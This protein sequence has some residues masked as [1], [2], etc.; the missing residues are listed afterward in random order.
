MANLLLEL[1]HL[2]LMPMLLIWN[3][4]KQRVLQIEIVINKI[5]CCIIICT[6]FYLF[7]Y[8]SIIH[9]ARSLNKITTNTL[10]FV[11]ANVGTQTH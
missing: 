3:A 5:N 10:D 9:V 7:L 4:Q 8:S 6:V 1:L 2:Q 11:H